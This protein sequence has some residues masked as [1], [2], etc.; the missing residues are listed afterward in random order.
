MRPLQCYFCYSTTSVHAGYTSLSEGYAYDGFW[1]LFSKEEQA[2]V[3]GI[4]SLDFG[5][6]HYDPFVSRWLSPDPLMEKYYGMSPYL[7]C[8]GN[9]VNLVEPDGRVW[10]N[11]EDAQKLKTKVEKRIEVFLKSIARKQITISSGQISEN[12]RK[13]L[14]NK[15]ADFQGRID[16]LRISLSDIELLGN[17]QEHSYIITNIPPGGAHFVRQM[18][19]GKVSI[20]SSSTSITLHEIA[21]VRQ[22][23]SSGGLYFSD[24]GKLENAGVRM[25]TNN[26]R[27]Q[28][29]VMSSMEIEA[30]KIQY[31]FDSSFPGFTRSLSG[32][33]LFSVGD[34]VAPDGQMAYMYIYQYAQY[35]KQMMG[36]RPRPG[37]LH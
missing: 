37:L 8:A 25:V 24:S 23:L 6:R 20:E 7:Y 15:I 13:R 30:Y 35:A 34:I 1:H 29:A 18:D 32:I 22:S 33:D 17:D 14:N 19:D 11:P 2:S 10:E 27:A 9:P 16:C 4:G 31:S 3:T 36:F 21:H 28:K 5:A 26:S 12:K